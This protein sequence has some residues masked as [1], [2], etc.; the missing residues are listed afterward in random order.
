MNAKA[1]SLDV[2]IKNNKKPLHGLLLYK[3]NLAK[4]QAVNSG[5]AHQNIG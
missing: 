3:G 4:K 1:K 5:L 2:M